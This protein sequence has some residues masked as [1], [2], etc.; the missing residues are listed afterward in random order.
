MIEFG[1]GVII[2]ILLTFVSVAFSLANNERIESTVLGTKKFLQIPQKK[3]EFF[4]PMNIEEEAVEEVIK[5]N[6]KRGLDTRME[7]LE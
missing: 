7:E 5:E 4:S 1:L 6:E 2:G 3:A